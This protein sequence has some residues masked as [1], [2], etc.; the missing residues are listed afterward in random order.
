MNTECEACHRP[1][2]ILYVID[3]NEEIYLCDRCQ[4]RMKKGI[5]NDGLLRYVHNN[6]K[7]G[8]HKIF[9]R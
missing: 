3:E 7:A 1:A 9:M 8:N 2:T 4:E 6:Y 5:L